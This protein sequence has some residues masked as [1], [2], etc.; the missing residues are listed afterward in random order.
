MNGNILL[1]ILLT[2]FSFNAN[3]QYNK[4]LT[5]GSEW[6]INYQ[7]LGA[8]NDFKIINGDTIINGITYKK[9]TKIPYNYLSDL[10]LL[11][12]DSITKKVYGF[13]NGAIN[14]RLL[15]D[16]SLMVGDTFAGLTSTIVL[17]SITSTINYDPVCLSSIPPTLNLTAPKVFYFHTHP[18]SPWDQPIV[19]VEGIGSLVG[20]I[21]ND[22]QW[23]HLSGYKI[24]CHY[25]ELG[26]RD[27]HYTS[28]IIATCL[29]HVYGNLEK[30][31]FIKDNIKIH[32]NPVDS[33]ISIELIDPSIDVKRIVLYD[34][35][36]KNLGSF[37]I[38]RA[39]T[40]NISELK[41]GF[42][43]AVF[44]LKNGSIISHKILKK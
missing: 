1:F 33:E 32:P 42:Y 2:F 5:E 17:D 44:Y 12:E 34:L 30:T 4:V 20:L 3:C 37:Q 11:R 35:F 22:W 15:Y 7:G 13:I 26:H 27:Y 9:Y 40:I 19:W 24:L 6:Y 43:L 28:C 31:F 21:Y 16:F 38:N 39:T 8:E 23:T 29:G 10:Q 36:G 14:E 41:K 18:S 25:N